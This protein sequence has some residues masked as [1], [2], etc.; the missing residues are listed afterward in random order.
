MAESD[1]VRKQPGK[2]YLVGAG[3]GAR[4]LLTLKGRR[5]LETADVVIYDYLAD[6]ALLSFAPPEA[7]KIYAGKRGGQKSLSQAEIEAL[8]VERARSGK[9]VVR[10]KG[11]DPF[12]FGRGG[13]EA[14][15][16]QDH[17][18]PFEI[19]PGVTSAIAAPAYAGIP[20]TH[21]DYASSVSFVAA[22]E[23][24]EVE[25]G[26]QWE[27]L[28]RGSHTLVLLMG[29]ANLAATMRRLLAHGCDPE[30]P[31][32]LIRWGTKSFQETLVGTVSDIADRARERGFG[33]PAVIVV[34]EVVNLRERLQWF[35][36][37]PLFGRRIMVTRPRSK[38]ESLARALEELGAEVIEFPTIRIVPPQSYEA[39]DRAV[40]SL[41][42]YDWLLF[43]SANGV[44]AFFS[45]LL[46]AGKD[47]RALHRC[48]VAAIGP[49]TAAALERRGVL[50][51]VVP[52]EFRA[53][54]LLGA[55]D[56]ASMEGK[57]ALLPRAAQ[58]REALPRTLREWGAEVDV[59]EAYRA[60]P[61]GGD[62]AW[63]EEL[64]SAG[65]LDLVSFTSS[66]TVR[67]FV[68]LFDKGETRAKVSRVPVACIG[69]VT[70]A[71]A[72]ELGLAVAVV[73]EDYTAAGLAEAIAR[74]FGAAQPGA[75]RGVTIPFGQEEE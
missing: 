55:L 6:R 64:L 52:R 50:A 29:M 36:N 59:V 54:G 20:L 46:A 47:V 27:H 35:E 71:T 18:V 68:E 15:H 40:R 7:E 30:R 63:V 28:A 1:A 11:G 61:A 13:E 9:V 5:C 14:E 73:A 10:L 75:P 70:A 25:P 45:R 23:S 2:V 48:R 69:P 53:E 17:G 74:Y 21:R 66:S 57:R 12:I 34:G 41:E 32:A 42:R 62:I 24:W 51:D 72:S 8:M 65:A 19:V 58:A 3:P 49:E 67:H 44:G 31:V 60:V 33:P 22:H 56:P 4:E 43:T 39:L 26:F 16:L 37:K 38:A